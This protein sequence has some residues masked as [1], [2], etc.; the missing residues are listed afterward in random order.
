[1]TVE[2]AVDDEARHET[3]VYGTDVPDGVPDVA[4]VPPDFDLP[5]DCGHSTLLDEKPR[6]CAATASA[7]P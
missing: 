2:L 6:R 4:R 3:P 1:M 5:V 7:A